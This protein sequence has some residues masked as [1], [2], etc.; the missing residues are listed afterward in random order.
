[1]DKDM[2]ISKRV[3][4]LEISTSSYFSFLL[5]VELN[6]QKIMWQVKA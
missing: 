6:Y 2:L 4:K 1:M 5:E 3:G